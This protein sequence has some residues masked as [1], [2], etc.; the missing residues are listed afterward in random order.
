MCIPSKLIQL[1][2]FN[3]QHQSEVKECII[4]SVGLLTGQCCLYMVTPSVVPVFGLG[5]YCTQVY[6]V[7]ICNSYDMATRASASLVPIP[8]F[9]LAKWP[10]RGLSGIFGPI[11]WFLPFQIIVASQIAA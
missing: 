8:P 5:M 9:L 3:A 2:V 6:C 7:C 1:A 11:S 10:Q 4:L